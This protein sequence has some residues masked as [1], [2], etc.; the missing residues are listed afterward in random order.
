MDFVVELEE[1]EG[2]S[3]VQR[4]QIACELAAVEKRLQDGGDGMFYGPFSVLFC[5]ALVC[6]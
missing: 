4:S 2:M 1:S 6:A 3:E 5:K